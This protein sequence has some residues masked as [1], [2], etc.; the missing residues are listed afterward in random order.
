[1]PTHVSYIFAESYG[2]YRLQIH[3]HGKLSSRLGFHRE[4]VCADT[5]EYDAQMEFL[6]EKRVPFMVGHMNPGASDDAFFWLKEKGRRAASLAAPP[7]ALPGRILF[8]FGAERQAIRDTC[9]SPRRW[10]W[11]PP[12]PAAARRARRC[13]S[14]WPWKA[15]CAPRPAASR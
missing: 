15:G 13:P 2:R 3:Q 1:M 6:I 5:F 10:R 4:L 12:A 7:P 9:R 14:A 8:V 11:P